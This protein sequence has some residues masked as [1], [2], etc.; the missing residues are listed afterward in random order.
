MHFIAFWLILGIWIKCCSF[1]TFGH[2][3]LCKSHWA[4][5]AL[6]FYEVLISN[7]N[8]LPGHLI[9][10]LPQLKTGT[11]IN[12][13]NFFPKPS[14]QKGLINILSIKLLLT[15]SKLSHIRVVCKLWTSNPVAWL[16]IYNKILVL[17]CWLYRT[18]TSEAKK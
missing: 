11:R 17:Y 3:F 18:R 14:D 4:I 13:Q 8:M 6:C 15:F 10:F 2:L 16:N 5:I 7:S 9:C 1:S 12:I